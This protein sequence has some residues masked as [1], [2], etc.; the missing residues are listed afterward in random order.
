MVLGNPLSVTAEAHD[1]IQAAGESRFILGTGCVLPTIAPRA[2]I[3]AARQA[4]DGG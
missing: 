1:A 2:N 4:V 3:M